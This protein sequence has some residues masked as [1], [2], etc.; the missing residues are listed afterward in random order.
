MREAGTNRIQFIIAGRSPT[1]ILERFSEP[2]PLMRKHKR[3]G[4]QPGR[5][6]INI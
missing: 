1:N 5:E 3:P 4:S 6:V 2:L